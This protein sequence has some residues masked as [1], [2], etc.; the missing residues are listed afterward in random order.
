MALA[1]VGLAVP[2]RL[3]GIAGAC[4]V[5]QEGTGGKHSTSAAVQAAYISIYFYPSPSL[6]IPLYPS[7]SLSISVYFSLFLFLSSPAVLCPTFPHP[8][9]HMP[10]FFSPCSRSP[11]CNLCF[12]SPSSTPLFIFPPPPLRLLLLCFVCS[13]WE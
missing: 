12:V 1:S 7:L 3:T 13:D 4:F 10:S 9:P 5:L 11:S 2:A 6:S 8:L